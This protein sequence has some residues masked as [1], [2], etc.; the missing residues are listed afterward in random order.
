M[1]L[2]YT[3]HILVF[4]SL[5]F[6]FFGLDTKKKVMIFWGIFFTF[7]GGLRW[8]IGGDWDQY[9]EHF[10]FAEFSNIFNYDRYGT[11]SE[12]LE[13]G[14]V[15][16]N[17]FIKFIFGKFYWYNLIVCGFLQ[18]T[19]YKF[20][21]RFCRSHPLIMYCWIIVAAYNYF[22]VR[23]GLSVGI[24]Y[25]AYHFL[26]NRDLKKYV[27]VVLC[28]SLIH[29]Q[30]LVMLPLYWIGLIKLNYKRFIAVYLFL[31][32]N[33]IYFKDYFMLLA[34]IVGGEL[35]DKAYLYTQ[36]ETD[37]FNGASYA[38]WFLNF[39]LG[40]MFIWYRNTQKLT[41]DLWYNTLINLFVLYMGVFIVFSQGSG[42]LT[43]LNASIGIGFVIIFCSTVAKLIDSK[44][45]T[46]V[47][48]ALLFYVIYYLYKFNQVGTG[49]FFKECNVPYRTI[50][51][52]SM[53]LL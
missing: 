23:S 9:Y 51:D 17:A 2:Y 41:K 8:R 22:P 25:W 3:I 16:L 38:S 20:C 49:F 46:Y 5:L 6:E 33:A 28:A 7:F 29:N 30:C 45:K 43:R 31:I 50:F 19:I 40:I 12:K 53:S 18:F 34:S 36:V 14:F 27:L 15:F 47:I 44:N 10:K 48:L 39:I 35:G 1:E 13:P 37:G 26:Q 42:D 24:V 4:A 21:L 11:G 32:F 52:Y